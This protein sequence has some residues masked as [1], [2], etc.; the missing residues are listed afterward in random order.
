MQGVLCEWERGEGWGECVCKHKLVQYTSTYVIRA[1]LS[2][3]IYTCHMSY[4]CV[5][6]DLKSERE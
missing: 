3:L 1:S 2:E 4:V 6:H 5:L